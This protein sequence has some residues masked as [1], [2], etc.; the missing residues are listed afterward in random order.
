MVRSSRID[1]CV[2]LPSIRKPLILA[3]HTCHGIFCHIKRFWRM[4]CMPCKIMEQRKARTLLQCHHPVLDAPCQILVHALKLLEIST[5]SAFL[6]TSRIDQIAVSKSLRTSSMIMMCNEYILAESSI[7]DDDETA[8]VRLASRL[9]GISKQRTMCEF[10][11]A[12]LVKK[13][14]SYHSYSWPSTLTSAI[15]FTKKRNQVA[16]NKLIRY[17]CHAGVSQGT[18]L[19]HWSFLLSS[20]ASEQPKNPLDLRQ[21]SL[22]K[23]S[24]I[25]Y[26]VE[27][28]CRRD[29]DLRNGSV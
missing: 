18:L 14:I 27:N 7:I 24:G 29:S 11:E 16:Y 10:G 19:W 15:C 1:I 2:R 8:F 17:N 6:I 9:W 3:K 12:H 23:Q 4:N 13:P 28:R 20:N 26:W 22:Q 25:L 21:A 5:S